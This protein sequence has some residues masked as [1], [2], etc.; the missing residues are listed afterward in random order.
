MNN[1][2][3]ATDRNDVRHFE[4]ITQGQ[5]PRYLCGRISTEGNNPA[6][7]NLEEILLNCT[8]SFGTYVRGV[9]LMSLPN[10]TM[11]GPHDRALTSPTVLYEGLKP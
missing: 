4:R 10:I 9:L 7:P 5:Q 11:E 6:W 2:S 1:I 3:G 8:S